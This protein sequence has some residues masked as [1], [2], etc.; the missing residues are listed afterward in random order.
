MSVITI[1]GR[2]G[3]GAPEIGRIVAERLNVDYVDREIIAQVA[4]RLKLSETEVIAKEIPTQTLRERIAIALKRDYK[5]G[6]GAAIQGTYLPM[7]EMPLDDNRYLEA[8]STLVRELAK[9]NALVIHGRGSQFILKGDPHAFHVSVVA[10]AMLRL[11]RV[12]EEMQMSEEEANQEI[13]QTDSSAHEFMKKYFGAEMDDPT[14]Y[15]LVISTGRF[16]Y[17]AAATAI[18]EVLR[19]RENVNA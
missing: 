18:L 12:M 10:P 17:D 7:T 16:T 3:S 4:S 2:L 5:T 1:R 6:V 14:G 15:D 11:N 9:T 19:I 13:T 8:L